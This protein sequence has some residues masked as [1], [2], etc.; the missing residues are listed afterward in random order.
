M[1]CCDWRV[2]ADTSAELI[3]DSRTGRPV[4][5]CRL[6]LLTGHCGLGDGSASVR[7]NMGPGKIT[8][9]GIGSPIFLW[10]RC[11]SMAEPRRAMRSGLERR[12]SRV[13]EKPLRPGWQ[14]ASSTRS[15]C[16]SSSPA[17]NQTRHAPSNWRRAPGC[18]RRSGG[19]WRAIDKAI[20][21]SIRTDFAVTSRRPWSKCGR[22]VSGESLRRISKLRRSRE[23][24]SCRASRRELRGRGAEVRQARRRQGDVRVERDSK[25]RFAIVRELLQCGAV[26]Q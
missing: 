13:P 11:H 20:R 8:L 1:Q 16:R 25:Q 15:G 14:A 26:P 7:R 9:A 4:A 5:P 3:A 23:R 19:N 6:R 22:E 24:R 10:I 17:P 21:Y 12:C 2:H 18:W